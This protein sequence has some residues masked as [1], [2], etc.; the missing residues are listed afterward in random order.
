MGRRRNSISVIDCSISTEG[1]H[2]WYVMSRMIHRLIAPP[3][4][5]CWCTGRLSAKP[6]EKKARIKQIGN[7]TS[8]CGGSGFIK[9]S[10]TGHFS[11][12]PLSSLKTDFH[13]GLPFTDTSWIC[14]ENHA[15][16]IK[17]FIFS[18]SSMRN[19]SIKISI[20]SALL[21]SAFS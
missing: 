2:H 17:W 11:K 21:I 16:I 19:I 3:F 8:S 10:T 1:R 6:E 12:E 9:T 14:N 13:S 20:S 18:I 15:T 7:K 5:C 4:G